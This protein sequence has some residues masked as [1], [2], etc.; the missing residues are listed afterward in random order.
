MVCMLL[1]VI[2]NIYSTLLFH[3]EHVKQF[4]RPLCSNPL[5]QNISRHLS[6]IMLDTP[7]SGQV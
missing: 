6:D 7:P 4:D 3:G 1:Q 2:M 5:V